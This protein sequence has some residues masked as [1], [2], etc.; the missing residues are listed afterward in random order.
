MKIYRSCHLLL[1][2]SYIYIADHLILA[3]VAYSDP[4]HC[5]QDMTHTC[6]V[7]EGM[8]DSLRLSK[9]VSPKHWTLHPLDKFVLSQLYLN[10]HPRHIP[11]HYSKKMDLSFLISLGILQLKGSSSPMK[12]LISP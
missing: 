9:S 3:Q 2:H 1:G 7:Y 8:T 5:W 11:C 10:N 6:Y 4:S 12:S